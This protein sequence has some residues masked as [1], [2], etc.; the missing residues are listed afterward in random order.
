MLKRILNIVKQHPLF[1]II[2]VTGFILRIIAI[3]KSPPSLNWDEVSHGYNAYSLL[4]TGKDEWGV[5]WPTIFRAYGDYKLPV[6]IYLTALSESVFGLTTLAVRM[7]SI[8]SGALL[9]LF[10]YLLVDKLFSKRVAVVTA[11]LVAIEPWSLFLS[12]GAF[13]AN[14]AI[15]F[16]VAGAYFFLKGLRKKSYLVIASVL[17][18]LSVWTYNSARIFVPL[19]IFTLALI[20]R[21]KLKESFN[22]NKKM[23][24]YSGLVLIFFFAPMFVQ[25]I[26][27][28]GLARYGWTAILDEG[29]INQI[30]ETRTTSELSPVLAR[31]RFNKA[32]YFIPRFVSNWSSHYSPDFLFINGGSHY[33]FSVQ[34]KGVLYFVNLLFLTLGVTFAIKNRRKAHILILSWFLLGPIASSITREAPHVLRSATILPTPMI[35]SA[36]GLLGFIRW[37]ESKKVGKTGFK[38]S[39]ILV[40]LY[41]IVI[42]VSTEGY[43]EEYFGSYREKYSWSWQYGYKQVVEYIKENYDKYNKIIVTKKYGEPHEFILFHWP[44]EPIFFQ[45]DKQLVRFQQS[46]WFWVDRFDKFYFVNDWNIPKQEREKFTLES[47]EEFDCEKESCLLITSPGNSPKKWR[48]LNT[49]NFLDG[50]PVFEIYEN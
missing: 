44:W 49:V 35:L 33:Q 15:G 26:N 14:L 7:P 5:S 28:E 4:K 23:L 3:E 19:L 48:Q 31:L 11:T 39:H 1:I 46:N 45:E 10:T 38:L 6:Y 17:F 43:L 21:E 22:K 13:E 24:F 29:A 8:I 34:G 41:V 37:I 40:G 18:G 32:T 25:M 42:L 36:L 12:R 9:V 20:Y 30:N 47:G 50:Q 27:P 2:F 16:I